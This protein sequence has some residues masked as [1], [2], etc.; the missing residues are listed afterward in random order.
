MNG[1]ELETSRLKLVEINSSHLNNLFDIYSDS[2]TMKYWDR[3]AHKDLETTKDLLELLERRIR[4]GTG[5]SWGIGLKE[6]NKNIIGTI[7]FNR[8][9]K[10]GMA[11][12]GYILSKAFWNKGIM[13]EALK[14]IIEY[15]FST[16]E[17]QRMEAHI[18][19]G[20]I[21]SEKLLQQIGF[22]KEGLLRQKHFYKDEYHD[23]MYYGLLRTD[24]RYTK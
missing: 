12:I 8:F 16:L 11:T 17:I 6:D 14:V 7:S 20:N 21:N 5:M 2:E 10:N 23:M 18:I 9:K 22:Q 4:E 24:E 13:T 15:G 1:A 3:Y 19:P